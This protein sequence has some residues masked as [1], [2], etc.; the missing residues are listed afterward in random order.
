MLANKIPDV[1]SLGT[2]LEIFFFL[3]GGVCGLIITVATVYKTFFVKKEPAP[4]NELI[5]RG[6]MVAEV[7][8]VEDLIKDEVRRADLSAKDARDRLETD[9]KDLRNYTQERTHVI[10]NK[11]H[12]INLRIVYMMSLLG[13]LC[14]KQG[15]ILP[16]EP[17]VAAQDEA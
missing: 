9:L 8:R 7:A 12:V 10:N 2:A 15:I 17:T 13:Q 5:T 11:M 1:T 6:E 14:T 3:S 16:Q 4:S